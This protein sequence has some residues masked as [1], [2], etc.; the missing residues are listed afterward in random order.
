MVYCLKMFYVFLNWP[1]SLVKFEASVSS[2]S[3]YALE[4]ADARIKTI[5]ER[6]SGP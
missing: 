4:S 2:G 1:R 6:K 3:Q 5:L